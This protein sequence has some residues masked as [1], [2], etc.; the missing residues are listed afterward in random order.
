MLA[1]TVEEFN[2]MLRELFESESQCFDMLCRIAE[3]TLVS[4][5]RSKCNASGVLLKNEYKD[6]MQEIYCKLIKKS[7][8]SFFLRNGVNGGT[9]DDPTEFQKWMFTVA[10]NLTIDYIKKAKK[11]IDI[12]QPF[13]EDEEGNI[14]ID[15][16]VPGNVDDDVSETLAHGFNIAIGLNIRVYKILTWI[17]HS[18][19]IVALDVTRIE[20]NGLILRMFK[21]RSLCQMWGM[22]HHLSK[23]ISWMKTTKEQEQKIEKALSAPYDDTHEYGEMQYQTFFMKKG[24]KETI[25]DWINRVNSM[26]RKVIGNGALDN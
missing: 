11:H 17:A 3:K 21:H 10:D 15:I 20:A 7:V 1:F 6:V 23:K 16:T 12:R 2:I 9:N 14:F 18:Y 13:E 22:L 8:N 4:R 26:I 24:E 19:F 5:V 25:S